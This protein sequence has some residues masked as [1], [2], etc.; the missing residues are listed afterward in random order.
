MCETCKIFGH[1]KDNC[2]KNK[3]NTNLKH[4]V[5][6]QPTL[7]T[8]SHRFQKQTTQQKR[9]TP[10]KNPQ[11]GQS[12][13]ERNDHG[14]P[15][16]QQDSPII[17]ADVNPCPIVLLEKVG[18]SILY[19]ETQALEAIV[20]FAK[21]S[22]GDSLLDSNPF[23]VF[24]DDEDSESL[25]EYQNV[26]EEPQ[27]GDDNGLL[28]GSHDGIKSKNDTKVLPSATGNN[29]IVIHSNS[30]EVS[31]TPPL[32]ILPTSSS[33]PTPTTPTINTDN[34]V[35]EVQNANAELRDVVYITE[36]VIDSNIQITSEDDPNDP[37]IF[38]NSKEAHAEFSG[39]ESTAS[40]KDY[41]SDH[42]YEA[43]IEKGKTPEAESQVV[44]SPVPQGIKDNRSRNLVE[45]SVN[46][47]IQQEGSPKQRLLET[48]VRLDKYD[49][50]RKLL[51]IAGLFVIIIIVTPLEGYGY[52]GTQNSLELRN[53]L[54][55]A[56]VY[57]QG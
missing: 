22:G 54:K 23:R 53:F 51:V 27:P 6:A 5:T 40:E 3:E 13:G 41:F 49:A 34:V 50:I 48:K 33:L 19:S 45:G 39:S 42:T 52:A 15:T 32:M 35:E 18:P 17:I 31:P 14:V 44:F 12:S 56:N 47:T 37:H 7:V 9:W 10:K 8:K 28:N 57:T 16:G 2:S 36:C 55:L 24:A 38:L 43:R 20:T 4:K 26:L 11:Q 25:T 21:A 46:Q 30:S 29:V 1:T